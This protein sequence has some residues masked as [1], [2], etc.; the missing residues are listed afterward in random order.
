MV[1]GDWGRP[2]VNGRLAA[3][4]LSVDVGVSP[5]SASS[6][7]GVSDG[8]WAKAQSSNAAAGRGVA[9]LGLRPR[10]VAD[11]YRRARAARRN[12]HVDAQGGGG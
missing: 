10:T 1:G 12:T 2:K 11:P 5:G 9:G 6:P 8:P 3:A 4:T 7:I